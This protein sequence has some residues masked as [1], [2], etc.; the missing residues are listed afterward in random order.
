MKKLNGNI[1]NADMSAVMTSTGCRL[2]SLLSTDSGNVFIFSTGCITAEE[3]SL[4]EKDVE[5]YQIQTMFS[6]MN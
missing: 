5:R 2:A 6:G 1:R 3:L 4:Q